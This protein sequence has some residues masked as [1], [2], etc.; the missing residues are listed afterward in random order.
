MR[1]IWG[2]VVISVLLLVMLVAWGMPGRMMADN[3]TSDEMT[4][5]PTEDARVESRNMEANFGSTTTGLHVKQNSVDFRESMLKFDLAGVDA[6]GQGFKAKLRLYYTYPGSTVPNGTTSLYKLPDP[7]VWSETSV[8]WNTRPTPGAALGSVANPSVSG[9]WVE[10]DIT[11][12]ITGDGVHSFYLKSTA[13]NNNVYFNSREDAI[14]K[15]ELVI[16]WPV[17]TASSP[18]DGAMEVPVTARTAKINF[19]KAM[20]LTSMNP[21]SIV[22]TREPGSVPVTYAVYA[23]E[24]GSYS[25]TLPDTLS[26]RRSY[27]ITIKKTVRFAD[28]SQLGKDVV[29]TFRT[30]PEAKDSLTVTRYEPWLTQLHLTSPESVSQG[31]KGGEGAQLITTLEP[32]RSNADLMLMGLDTYSIWRSDDGGSNWRI[33]DEGSRIAATGVIDAAIDPEEDRLAFAASSADNETEVT[34]GAGLYKSEDGGHSWRQVLQGSYYSRLPDGYLIRSS[35][36]LI[37]FGPM[38]GTKRVVYA[39]FHDEGVFRSVDSGETWTSIGLDG[40]IVTELHYDTTGGRLIAATYGGGLFASEDEGA[41]WT[42]K[43]GGLTSSNIRSVA[44]LPSDPDSWVIVAG[45][46]AMYRTS[47]AGTTWQPIAAPGGLPTGSSLKRAVFGAPDSSG[48]S[49]LYLSLHAM[50]YPFRVSDDMGAS[51]SGEPKLHMEP[52]YYQSERGWEGEAVAVDPYD[53]DTVWVSFRAQ[54]FKST[55]GGL[56]FNISN[57]GYSGARARA[58]LFN[59][60][61]DNDIL[62]GMTDIGIAKSVDPGSSAVYPMFYELTVDQT[63]KIRVP[64]MSNAKTVSG[65]VRDPNDR[66]HLFISTGNYAT[67]VIAESRDG[68]ESFKQLAG[69]AGNLLTSIVYHPQDKQVIY[70]DNRISSDNGATWSFLSRDVLAMSP[71]DGDTVYSANTIYSQREVD[72]SGNP[73]N[74]VY[75]SDDRGATWTI[76][77]DL[78]PA[79]R[80]NRIMIREILADKFMPGRL[81]LATNGGVYRLDGTTLTYFGAANGLRPHPF[82]EIEVFSLDQDP[83]NAA[84][85]VA[86]GVDYV[87]RAQGAGLF[88]TYDSGQ[89]WM[90]VPEIPGKA[91]IWHVKF[92]PTASKVYMATS[93]GT[94]V[95]EFDKL[96]HKDDFDNSDLVGWS[97]VAGTAAV[98]ADGSGRALSLSDAVR[99]RVVIGSSDWTGYDANTWIKV[100]SWNVNG[101][102]SL[103]ANYL[104]DDN[105]YQMAYSSVNG[106]LS[107]VKRF[108]GVETT[109]EESVSFALETG[110]YHEFQLVVRH[111]TLKGCI[112]GDCKVI[113]SDSS[114]TSGKAGVSTD[115]QPA[116]V[117]DWT[118]SDPYLFRDDFEDGQSY[119]WTGD[120]GLWTVSAGGIG[121]SHAYSA[122]DSVANRSMNGSREWKDYSFEAS[123][124]VDSWNSGAWVS[125]YSRYTD[126]ANYYLAYYSR[127]DNRFRIL[128]RVNGISTVMATSAAVDLAAGVYHHIRFN[129]DG[130]LLTLIFNGQT[131]ASVSDSA[132]VRGA[133]GLGTT[134]QPAYFDDIGIFGTADTVLPVTTVVVD[135]ME[136]SGWYTG[137]PLLKFIAVDYHTTVAKTEYSIDNGVNWLLYTQPIPLMQEGMLTIHY[138]STDSMGNKEQVKQKVIQID[139]TAPVSNITMSPAQPDG[140]N[141]WYV[142]PV[143]VT[144]AAT[145]NLSRVATSE[146]SLDGGTTWHPYTNS[147]IFDRDGQ[148]TLSYRST[149]NAGNVEMQRT[150][151]I[152]IDMTVPTASVA[153]SRSTPTNDIV[154]ASITPSEHVTITN[155]GGSNSYSFIMNGSFTFEFVDDAGNQGT[156]T[157]TINNMITKSKGVPG[158]PDLSNDN[159]YDT[160]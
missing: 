118:V 142:N 112:D 106:K 12:A 76:I 94:W 101:R 139:K 24:P 50:R 20:D 10:F 60:E 67:S 90:R 140:M 4:L 104:D 38:L 9:T 119:G 54:L 128:K 40:F 46:N 53:P 29:R 66:N 41:T 70:A 153:Y 105:Y 31:I 116:Y 5:Y 121:R 26:Y 123:F 43:S 107:I 68:G 160:G 124:K 132:L 11:Q 141:G 117:D 2:K 147:L 49:R 135:G 13:W 93:A 92:H 111:G 151:V 148:H 145:D 155:N 15:P 137:N 78:P 134:A 17:V 73:I 30:A 48:H 64:D 131:V 25:L 45:P 74:R 3:G 152:N 72:G 85:L 59:S 126:A 32:S 44:V 51:W 108:G 154:V 65:M 159:G 21:S 18:S 63:N 99:N 102:V 28:G 156:A 36:N 86:G 150:S 127:S 149:D 33:S 77:A 23:A 157:A 144:L 71:F 22:V 103:L 109:L 80:L 42:L 88:E 98:A 81:W 133:I 96:L 129:A 27:K 56:T 47:D 16:S 146:Y 75:R 114:L 58:F 95:Y 19:R 35:G 84:H 110:R 55:D 14:N 1:G 7:G 62:I 97:T 122:N 120:R 8:T 83:N 39:A 34:Q 82:G 87:G 91:D 37:Q 130:S 69:T 113:A 138:R 158:K 57:S 100:N 143:T 52:V 79:P 6:R 61:N 125:L 89:N 136:R 115:D